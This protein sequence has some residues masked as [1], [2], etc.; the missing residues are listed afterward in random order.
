[1]ELGRDLPAHG[2]TRAVAVADGP[3]QRPTAWSDPAFAP[4]R[5]ALQGDSAQGEGGGGLA[6]GLSG[7]EVERFGVG[8][9]GG[10]LRTI[11]RTSQRFVKTGFPQP[12]AEMFTTRY[13]QLFHRP[14]V[15][16]A[17]TSLH[18]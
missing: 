15:V 11:P 10:T 4:I 5:H 8:H 2:Q 6:A 9:H 14:H 18:K 17:F 3:N 13:R 16:L 12:V 7:E 1:L